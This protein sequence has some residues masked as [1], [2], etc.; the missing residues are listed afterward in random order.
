MPTII[1]EGGFRLFF[2]SNDK[3]ELPYVHVQYQS[4]VA[5]F[6]IHPVSLARNLGMNVSELRKASDLVLKHESLI[7][8]K[9][10]EYFS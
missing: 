10:D 9:W 5:K 6:W 8:E 7:K 2:Y 3:K 4:S 1:I